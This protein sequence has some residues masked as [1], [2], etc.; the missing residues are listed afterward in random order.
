MLLAALPVS[1]AEAPLVFR[2]PDRTRAEIERAMLARGERWAIV[3]GTHG[4]GA[5]ILEQRAV[6]LARRMLADS[7]AAVADTAATA[8]LISA[9]SLV[10]IGGPS[11]NACTAACSTVPNATMRLTCS[12]PGTRRRTMVVQLS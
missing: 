6:A 5:K 1:A 10:L 7:T 4:A 3:Y 9:R 11:S 8:S 12:T 2:K